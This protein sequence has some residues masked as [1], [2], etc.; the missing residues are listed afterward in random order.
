MSDPHKFIVSSN[1]LLGGTSDGGDG[2]GHENLPEDW[3]DEPPLM[4]M[5]KVPEDSNAYNTMQQ[6]QMS[7]HCRKCF[8]NN[9]VKGIPRSLRAAG[10]IM[11][12]VRAGDPLLKNTLVE[13][14]AKNK[15]IPVFQHGWSLVR[16]QLFTDES[17]EKELIIPDFGTS[18]WDGEEELER[19][20]DMINFYQQMQLEHAFHDDGEKK[21]SEEGQMAFARILFAVRHMMNIEYAPLI[22]DITALLLSA[23]E[24]AHVFAT[25]R[26]ISNNNINR[27][28]LV[29]Q[30]D[31]YAICRAFTNLFEKYH[32]KTAK[33]LEENG[34]QLTSPN[35]LD[36]IFKR[37]FI[38]LLKYE[39]V[40]RIMDLYTIDGLKV[41]FR[42]GITLLKLC[43][44]ALKTTALQTTPKSTNWCWDYIREFT[45][46]SQFDFELLLKKAYGI[47]GSRLRMRPGIR[48]RDFLNK[49][50]REN[51]DWVT[52]NIPFGKLISPVKPMS[53]TTETIKQ[54][55]A[56]LAKKSAIRSH[57][58]EW[59][60]SALKSTK[61]DL[62][63]TTET[64][65]RSLQYF[66]ET[67][68][69]ARHTITM[70]EVL[71]TGHVIGMYASQPWK[72][73]PR[74]FGDGNSFLFRLSPDP[75]CFKWSINEDT[76]F[77]DIENNAEEISFLEQIMVAKS[78]FLSMG[79]SKDGGF[80]LRIDKDLLTGTSS[81]AE[82]FNNDP[83][84]A[85]IVDDGTTP[86]ELTFELGLVE[87]YRLL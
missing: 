9:N 24:E 13:E 54:H 74:P 55:H 80:G 79:G 61:L 45:H 14:K 6:K 37:F 83:L 34:C 62:I 2:G 67:V 33:I 21:W 5:K 12:I 58:T 15:H 78:D 38:P 85:D 70:I 43:K 28:F 87:V 60:P 50:A 16:K 49:I 73:N 84:G 56:V 23:M 22:P 72:I 32:P 48:G 47:Y 59:V 25:L 29:N 64:M 53:L 68:Q 42:F 65:G 71:N 7:R 20:T 40:L 52:E 18:H 86:S 27:F 17:D 8:N 35:A 77:N 82:G 26:F 31:H 11:N 1:T 19:Q 44:R 46:D 10:W 76:N 39:H 81:R 69:K 41:L 3:N 4:K 51:E 57:L 75:T 63:Y 36:P 30:T 66:Y